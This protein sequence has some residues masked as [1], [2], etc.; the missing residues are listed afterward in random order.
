MHQKRLFTWNHKGPHHERLHIIT[1]GHW[2]ATRVLIRNIMKLLANHKNIGDFYGDD[3]KLFERFGLLSVVNL[4]KGHTN[5]K[6]KMP[7]IYLILGV[8]TIPHC[9]A[10]VTSFQGKM[11]CKLSGHLG[12]SPL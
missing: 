4:K 3:S 11:G 1:R 10:G 8:K 7:R 9:L 12:L 6:R 5:K 2:T